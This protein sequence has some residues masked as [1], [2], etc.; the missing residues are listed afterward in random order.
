[1]GVKS[2]GVKSLGGSSMVMGH[3]QPQTSI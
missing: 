1:L 2:L 3:S